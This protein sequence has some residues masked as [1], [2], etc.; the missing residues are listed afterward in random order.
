MID[1]PETAVLLKGTLLHADGNSVSRMREEIAR[2]VDWSELLRIAIPHGVLPLLSS[3]LSAHAADVMPPVTLAQLQIFRK[4]VATRNLEQVRELIRI[5]SALSSEGIRV[6]PFKGPA[7]AISAYG[8][9]NLRESHDLDFWVEPSRFA[10]VNEWLRGEGY[11][12]V[13]HVEGVVRRVSV[14]GGRH[15]EFSSPDGRIFIEVKDHLEPSVDAEFDPPFDGVWDRRGCTNLHESKIPILS[16]EDL[17]LG[18][19]VHGAKHMWRRL[20]W[21]VDFATVVATH[22]RIEWETMLLRAGQWRC[23]RRLLAAASLAR[24]V[25]GTE[26]PEVYTKAAREPAVRLVVSHICSSLFRQAQRR[27]IRG[28]STRVLYQMRCCD[29]TGGRLRIARDAFNHVVRESKS[30]VGLPLFDNLRRFYGRAGSELNENP[31]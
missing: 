18:L 17:L 3:N 31:K 8:D 23:R 1:S 11:H 16:V 19:A 30:R 27:S 29:T 10:D 28:F 24:A 22:P 6:L 15:R 20:N 26:F 25:Y 13:E 21:I 5:M 9:I 7:L 4:N 2:G 14:S 12:P